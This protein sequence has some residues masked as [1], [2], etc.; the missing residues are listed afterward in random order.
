MQILQI[1]NGG[2]FNPENINSSFLIEINDSFLLF[3]CGYNV[4]GALL[5]KYENQVLDLSKL[6]W[7]FISHMDD[8]HMG[9]LKTLIYYMYFNFG[10]TLE[11]IS[12]GIDVDIYLKDMIEPN[13]PNNFFEGNWRFLEYFKKFKFGSI[14]PYKLT[15]VPASHSKECYGMFLEGPF[16]NLFISGDTKAIKDI[17]ATVTMLTLDT[18]NPTIVFH[19]YSNWNNEP[20]QVHACKTDIEST[21]SKRFRDSMYFYHND[22]L[23]NDTWMDCTSHVKGI[24]FKE[25]R[26][27]V[28]TDEE[29]VKAY[30]GGLTLRRELWPKGKT[31]SLSKDSEKIASLWENPLQAVKENSQFNDWKIIE[32]V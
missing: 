8:D 1:G 9:S 2:A 20:N 21:Y 13:Q 25:F 14:L 15:M 16:N 29:A 10:V 6:K 27:Y 19:D 22:E 30:E 11:I 26:P 4:F 7:V 17:E 12:G 3:D 18:M 23:F 31:V 32:G 5:K 28:L 24:Q